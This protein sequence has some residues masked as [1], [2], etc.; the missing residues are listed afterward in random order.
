MHGSIIVTILVYNFI[1][2]HIFCT[3]APKIDRRNLRTIKVHEGEPIALDIK[4]SGEPPPE[5]TWTLN[6]K[7][8]TSGNGLKRKILVFCI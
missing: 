6:G 3:V 2:K 7:S 4:V 5:V 1:K 8:V